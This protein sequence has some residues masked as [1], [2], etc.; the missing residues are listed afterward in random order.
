LSDCVAVQLAGIIRLALVRIFPRRE[1][2]NDKPSGYDLTVRNASQ[3]RMVQALTPVYGITLIDVLG[4]MIMIPLLPYYAQKFSASGVEVGALLATM[5]VASAVA[6]PFWGALS[7]RVG[8]K[9]IVLFSQ[10]ISLAAYLLIAWAP[11]LAMLFVARG[12]AG[13]GGGNIGVTQ[14][15][16]ADV[17]S[18]ASRDKAFAGFGVV[19]GAGIVLGPVLGGTLVHIGF[20]APFVASAAIELINIGLTVCFLPN[21]GG[22]QKRDKIDVVRTARAIW[23]Q[24]RIRSLILQHFLFIFAVTFFFAIFA[25]YLKRALDFGPTH[26]SYLIAVAGVVGGLA[27]WLVV[28][29]LAQRFGDALLSKVGLALSFVAY[30][31][32]GFAHT[33]ETFIA[34]LILWA[35]GASCI[36]PTLAALLS[37]SVPEDRRGA[38]LGFNDLM[39]NVGLMFA[40]ALGGFVI[41]RDVALIGI[42]PAFSL[43]IALILAW[44]LAPGPRRQADLQ[45][46]G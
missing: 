28:G 32:L 24:P 26:A 40:P 44:R 27:L 46:Q 1:P 19:F 38:M 15:Y 10:A 12:V 42:A 31:L 16:I 13:I 9:P 45:A 21:T 11:T 22:K 35:V 2:L 18:E 43:L 39:S 29:P 37:N 8:R 36:E 33:L 30:A 23:S 7:D 34:V 17:T 20:W 6:A 41:D 14:S 5:A 25:L 3:R 4:Y